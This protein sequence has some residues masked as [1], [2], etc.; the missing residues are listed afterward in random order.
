MIIIYA[1]KGGVLT[2][3]VGIVG[4]VKQ[5]ASDRCL[6]FFLTETN[7]SFGTN[8]LISLGFFLLCTALYLMTSGNVTILSGVFSI[9][10]LMVLVMFALANMRLKF[11]R[12]R[13]PRGVKI[14][15]FGAILGFCF[16]LIGIIGN[17]VYNQSLIIYFLIYLAFY[18]SVIL[19]T[20]KR[21]PIMK[22][23]L[24]VCQQFPTL[25]KGKTGETLKKLLQSMK[26][27]K[28]LFFTSTSD[29]HVLNKAM[30][31]ARDNDN[32][33]AIVIA[34]VYNKNSMD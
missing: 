16:M 4:L 14:S 27:F 28:V 8:H 21:V 31:Y 17:I 32:C 1:I 12:P 20:F 26:E 30:L 33:D 15:W 29:V 18:F 11:N 23:L 9:A 6:P 3:N 10:F 2:A 7:K 13:L 25:Y 24:Y 5:L 19:I 34:Y 22:L